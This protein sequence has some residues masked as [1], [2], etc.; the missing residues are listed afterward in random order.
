[1]FG[2]IRRLQDSG[3]RLVIIRPAPCCKLPPTSVVERTASTAGPLHLNSN[4]IAAT[5]APAVIDLTAEAVSP[6][7]IVRDD[8]LPLPTYRI[9]RAAA[10]RRGPHLRRHHD[11]LE[12]K[13]LSLSTNAPTQREL[14]IKGSRILADVQTY[15]CKK[16]RYTWSA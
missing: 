15:I 14:D 7:V 8:P 11:K 2:A 16:G 10:G 3:P 1:M 13:L 6:A 12:K 5:G 4:I 9:P